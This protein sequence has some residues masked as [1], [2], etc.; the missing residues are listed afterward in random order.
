MKTIQTHFQV[1]MTFD[2]DTIRR[3]FRAEFYGYELLK[4]LIWTGTGAALILLSLFAGASMALKA[5]FLFAG[6]LMLSMPDFLSRVA[7]EGIIM[8]RGH[9]VSQVSY[10]ILDTG[11][12]IENGSCL[13]FKQIDRLMEDD[14]YFYIFQNRQ[15]A[16]MLPKDGLHPNAPEDLRAYLSRLTGKPWKRPK[17]LWS[18]T[19]KDL[20]SILHPQ[21]R[22]TL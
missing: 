21:R 16:V 18:L 2:D 1:H 14:R 11:I 22:N 13:S 10:H 7:A 15:N 4:R 8:Q 19:L 3:M 9:A 5:A 20:I 17:S 12:A 6:C